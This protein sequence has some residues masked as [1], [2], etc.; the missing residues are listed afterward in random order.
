MASSRSRQAPRRR[1]LFSHRRLLLAEAVLVLG[2]FQ[3]ALRDWVMAQTSLPAPLRVAFGM[4]LI[5]GVFGG[6]LLL[7][8]RTV[9]RSLSTT[10][11]VVQKL[12]LP[13]PMVGVHALIFAVLFGLY[14][15]YWRMDDEVLRSL[16]RG[17]DQTQQAVGAGISRVRSR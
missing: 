15:H 13:T 5:L 6:L 14:A 2:L 1:P 11:D 17:A 10:H 16:E 7:V 9:E 12:P 4:A 8:R 3:M